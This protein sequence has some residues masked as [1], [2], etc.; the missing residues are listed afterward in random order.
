MRVVREDD[1][2]Q[3]SEPP[4]GMTGQSL[5]PWPAAVGVQCLACGSV[6]QPAK[7][8]YRCPMCGA[9]GDDVRAFRVEDP[10]L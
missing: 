6:E 8:A 3:D 1:C 7:D 9:I 10:R 5:R 2:A 4:N